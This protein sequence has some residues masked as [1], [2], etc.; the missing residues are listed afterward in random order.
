M[1]FV[2]A[3]AKKSSK[4][5]QISWSTLLPLWMEIIAY[6]GFIVL[7]LQPPSF[8]IMQ[9]HLNSLIPRDLIR[10]KLW[11]SCN[12]LCSKK[13]GQWVLT[14]SGTQQTNSAAISEHTLIEWN[15]TVCKC[16]RY[17]KCIHYLSC[18]YIVVVLEAC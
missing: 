12:V 16:L 8:Y 1:H 10:S 11:L 5:R 14:N 4:H 3:E 15:P 7:F 2:I 17:R 18:Q 9:L 13:S 6:F